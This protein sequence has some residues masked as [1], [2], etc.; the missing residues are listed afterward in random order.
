[1]VLGIEA[2]SCSG[3]HDQGLL[4]LLPHA[5]SC[6]AVVSLLC[7]CCCVRLSSYPFYLLKVSEHPVG[8]ISYQ[9]QYTSLQS[10]PGPRRVPPASLRCCVAYVAVYYAHQAQE[11]S[12]TACVSMACSWCCVA[13]CAAAAAA[14][15]GPQRSPGKDGSHYDPGCDLFQPSERKMVLTSD[16]FLIGMLGVLAAF[17]AKLGVAAMFNLYFVP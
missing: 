13:A 10:L 3:S 6:C 5:P 4:C 16:A 15:A 9:G 12:T 14:V 11:R 2:C 17:T 7:P 8:T 1:V